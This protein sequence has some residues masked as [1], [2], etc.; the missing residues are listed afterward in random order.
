MSEGVSAADSS[1][2]SPLPLAMF[3]VA[4]ILSASNAKS[5][6]QRYYRFNV[7]ILL[8]NFHPSPFQ[9]TEQRFVHRALIVGA[10]NFFPEAGRMM[11]PVARLRPI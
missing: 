7:S 8:A 5:Y 2:G 1:G 10:Y 6:L 3:T 9:H 11:R 4:I